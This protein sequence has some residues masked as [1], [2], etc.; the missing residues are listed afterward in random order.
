MKTFHVRT[1]IEKDKDVM[2]DK[3]LDQCAEIFRCLS[4]YVNMLNDIC[5]PD[6]D[7]DSSEEEEEEEEEE[8]DVDEAED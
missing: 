6:D 7:G 2:S 3:F 1:L 8:E 5:M 4:E